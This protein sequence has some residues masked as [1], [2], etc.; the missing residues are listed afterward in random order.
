M[1][2]VIFSNALIIDVQRQF[3]QHSSI[4][5]MADTHDPRL[6]D[7]LRGTGA[8]M[9]TPENILADMKDGGFQTY[10]WHRA[11]T[12]IVARELCLDADT[13]LRA[14]Y[15]AKYGECLQCGRALRPAMDDD[16]LICGVHIDQ[17]YSRLDAP[18]E[19][20]LSRGDGQNN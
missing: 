12:A 5:Q 15:R 20:V 9:W 4:G 3:G 6:V 16:Y 10:I 8:T 2:D 7:V 17:R 19:R 1:S 13:E 11:R 14:F 18:Y